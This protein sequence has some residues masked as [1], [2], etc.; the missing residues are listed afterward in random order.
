MKRNKMQEYG[1]TS[2]MKQNVTLTHKNKFLLSYKYTYIDRFLIKHHGK[3]NGKMENM[4]FIFN[5]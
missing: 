4:I 2:L 3:M 1:K 5:D